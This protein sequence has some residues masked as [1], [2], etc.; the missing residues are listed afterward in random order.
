MDKIEFAIAFDRLQR[1]PKRQQVLFKLLHG[2]TDAAI[3]ESLKIE[4]GTVRKQISAI[5]Q[6]FGLS[7]AKG[8]RR[9][10]RSDLIALFARYRPELLGKPI[11]TQRQGSLASRRYVTRPPIEAQCHQAICEPQAFLRIRGPSQIGKTWLL[12]RILDGAAKQGYHTVRLNLL[13]AD[14]EIFV[15]LDRF[16]RWFC[17]SIGKLLLGNH[18]VEEYW[19][20]CLGSNAS[21]T[22]YFEEYLLAN[23]DVPLVLGLDNVERLFAYPE[24]ASDFLNL[25]QA[26]HEEN[27]R[28]DRPA[29]LRLVVSHSYEFYPLFSPTLSFDFDIGT[30]VD[31]PEF[32]LQQVWELVRRNGFDWQRSQIEQLMA[33]L[34]GHPGLLQLALSNLTASPHLELDRLLQTAAGEGGLFGNYLCKYWLSL[35]E[36]PELARGMDVVANTSKPV[37][38]PL[39]IARQ[40]VRM[41][42]VRWQGNAVEPCCELY[43]Q[44]FRD[45]L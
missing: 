7:A 18:Q 14:R 9:S 44:Y 31:L 2:E 34:G 36:Y 16:L 39:D 3:A 23:I 45:R 30:P 11:D 17:A 26:W 37:Q 27:Q 1:S 22:A 33:T 25:L 6:T 8:R 21:C 24:I 41:G 19:D 20:R 4:A 38:L 28:S 10:K 40:L 12:G 43:R 29:R 32:D 15:N 5:C 13:L 35:Q 42:L